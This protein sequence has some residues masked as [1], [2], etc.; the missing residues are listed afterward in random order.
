M[1]TLTVTGAQP[2]VDALLDAGAVASVGTPPGERRDALSARAYAHPA[3]EER[4][5]VRLVSEALGDAEDLTMAFLGFEEP[6]AAIAVGVVREQALGFPAW[7]LV[8]DPA[9]GRHALDLVKD[10]EKL[11]RRAKSKPGN[12]KDGYDALATRLAAS[13]PHFLPT[14][15]EQAARAFLAAENKTYAAAYF[16]RAREAEHMYTLA[17]DESAQAASFLEFALAGA[18]SAKSISAYARRL[19]A[20]RTP[21]EAYE[22]FR[23]VCVERVAGGLPPYVGMAVD[24]KRLAKAAGRDTAAE[25]AAL[26]RELLPLAATG[27]AA[28]GFWTGYR[29]A[30]IRA[31]K[32]DATVRGLMLAMFPTMGGEANNVADGLWLEL[33]AACG[34]TAGLTGSRSELAPEELPADGASG[35]LMRFARHARRGWHWRHYR[36]AKDPDRNILRLVESMA[37]RL[38]EEGTALAL[39]AWRDADIDLIDLC[40]ELGLSV[41]DPTV[42]FSLDLGT[43]L[44]QDSDRA[45]SAIAADERFRRYLLHAVAVLGGDHGSAARFLEALNA[46]AAAGARIG[47]YRGQ[48]GPDGRTSLRRFARRVAAVPGV[49]DVVAQWQRELADKTVAAGLADVDEL[50]D[51]WLRN[52]EPELLAINPDAVRRVLD[53]DLAP[54]LA[55]GLR[56]G[57]FDEY[58]WP[59]LE[60]ALDRLTALDPEARRAWE[61][62]AQWPY[63]IVNRAGSPTTLVVG[64]QDIVFEHEASWP[65]QQN[66]NHHFNK[67]LCFTAG[68]LLV[69]WWEWQNSGAYWSSDPQ[70]IIENGGTRGSSGQHQQESLELPWGDRTFGGTP[71]KLGSAVWS[72]EGPVASDGVDYWVYTQLGKQWSSVAWQEFDPRTGK[73]GR[74]GVPRFFEVGAPTGSRLV[75]NASWLVPAVAGSERSPLGQADGLLGS[76]LRTLAD[77]SRICTGVDGREALIPV[78]QYAWSANGAQ[79]ILDIPGTERRLVVSVNGPHYSLVADGTRRTAHLAAA[80]FTRYARG[81]RSMPPLRFWHFLTVRDEAGSAALRALADE[82]AA[83]LLQ[84]GRGLD[85]DALATAIEQ[86]L[87][88]VTDKAL[89][90]G[91]AGYVDAA[92]AC[93]KRIGK[94]AEAFKA[95]EA[96]LA[97]AAAGAAQAAQEAAP[98]LT[99]SAE[100]DEIR[101]GISDA[102]GRF[103][104]SDDLKPTDAVMFLGKILTAAAPPTKE[105]AASLERSSWQILDQ[106]VRTLIPLRALAYRAVLDVYGEAGREAMLRFLEALDGSG[107][108]APGT[109]LRRILVI[110][111]D[112]VAASPQGKFLE[113]PN[114]RGVVV[115]RQYYGL[116]V[117]PVIVLEYSRTGEF[118]A[119]PGWNIVEDKPGHTWPGTAPLGEFVQAARARGPIGISPERAAEL[120]RLAGL[121]TVEAALLLGGLPHAPRSGPRGAAGT[122]AESI[123]VKV[124][125][126]TSASTRFAQLPARADSAALVGALLPSTPTELW[127]QGPHL[128]AAAA[129]WVGVHGMQTVLPDALRER[130]ARECSLKDVQRLV[131]PD[132]IGSQ[133]GEDENTGNLAWH[134]HGI[135]LSIYSLQW[136]AYE[137]PI[138]D[139]LRGRLPRALARLRQEVTG[140]D[141]SLRIGWFKDPEQFATARGYTLREAAGG[142]KQAGPFEFDG[143]TLLL[144]PGRLT[145]FE[146]RAWDVAMAGSDAP[147]VHL[148]SLRRLFSPD[149]DRLVASAATPDAISTPTSDA[150]ANAEAPYP[151]QDPTRSVPDLVDAVAA[152]HTLSRDAAALYLMLLALPDPTDRNQAAWTGWK[153][154][155]LKQAREELA[156]TDLVVSGSRA[157][158]GR[159]L[160]LP[161]GWRNH[162]A[163]QLPLEQWKDTYMSVRGDGQHEAQGL[164]PL[165]PVMDLYRACWQRVLDGDAPRYEA[166]ETGRRR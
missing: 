139:P 161:G 144:Y 11:A 136:L 148:A 32:H 112:G 24:I 35:W 55:H 18:V 54:Y 159:T 162:A 125:A 149:F 1:S 8:H 131:N 123:G 50:L 53:L 158:A 117:T 51:T 142:R 46:L 109:A 151:A 70:V 92:V 106:I 7:A 91:I 83:A 115:G 25:D 4:V 75:P 98:T 38:R 56:A 12:A 89:R 132:V 42:E 86:H 102:Y 87:P 68:Q 62:T 103:I 101:M 13:V 57:I 130:A 33:L 43:W 3:L 74:A 104:D 64:A 76:R 80:Q 153:P 108:C 124:S 145:G 140:P 67:T 137:L 63:F 37:P 58:A 127:D 88:Q 29:A 97:N 77:G 22:R 66:N 81:T 133:E 90:A 9:N 160:F 163:P 113:T 105:Q 79:A 20:R 6:S 26:A 21:Q 82:Q 17:I 71:L 122:L 141:W 44:A 49:R 94:L 19:A 39:A 85:Q 121:A 128:E 36:T 47:G 16:T 155:R 31:A 157:R 84:V 14:Y 15:Y 150:S 110:P 23:R 165:L 135:A 143:Q 129:L 72:A 69:A 2:A 118:A 154:A 40:L 152:R 61:T 60:R 119:L 114:G 34:A 116:K 120:A 111:Q 45:L 107:L 48:Q 146:D 156:A 164:R 65:K 126:V 147:I 41:A 166:L 59:A 28:A 99:W 27:K 30:L 138:G 5:V 73:R 95:A 100:F 78:T 134:R 96:E 52:V 93:E 10:L